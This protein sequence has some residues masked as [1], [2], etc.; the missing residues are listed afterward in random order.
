MAK[1]VQFKVWKVGKE[2]N[3]PLILTFTNMKQANEF[4]TW[5]LINRRKYE[6]HGPYTLFTNQAQAIEELG[7]WER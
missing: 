1:F 7:F 3:L 6:K 5:C 4:D 2:S